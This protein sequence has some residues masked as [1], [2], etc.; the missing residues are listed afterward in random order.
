MVTPLFD[1]LGMTVR[2]Q[3]GDDFTHPRR[4]EFRHSQVVV[5]PVIGHAQQ[6]IPMGILVRGVQIQVDVSVGHV[7]TCRTQHHMCSG[8]VNLA[9]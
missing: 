5:F 3:L 7:R 6:G 4:H 2:L 1:A 9:T 8:T